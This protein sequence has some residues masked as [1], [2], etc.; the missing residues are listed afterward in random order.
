[1]VSIRHSTVACVLL[2][3]V[4]L[5]SCGSGRSGTPTATILR[6][7]ALGQDAPDALERELEVYN[8]DKSIN[9]AGFSLFVLDMWGEIAP[10]ERDYYDFSVR[11][12]MNGDTFVSVYA[13]NLT[14]SAASLFVLK[15]NPD[16]WKLREILPGKLYGGKDE[17]IFLAVDKYAGTLPFGLARVR[18]QDNGLTSGGGLV[19]EIAFTSGPATGS[20][21]VSVTA[22]ESALLLEDYI[23]ASFGDEAARLSWNDQ[24]RGDYDNNGSVGISDI[25]PIAMYFGGITGDSVG[26]DVAEGFIDRGGATDGSV[27]IA[28]I[29]PIAMYYGITIDGYNIYRSVDG[30]PEIEA[31]WLANLDSPSL[32]ISIER[33]IDEAFEPAEYFYQDDTMLDDMVGDSTTFVYRIV[34][35]GDTGESEY[36]LSDTLTIEQGEDTIPPHGPGAPT[37]PYLGITYM[38]AGD[39]RIKIVYRRNAVDNVTLPD[40]LRYFLYIGPPGGDAGIDLDNSIVIEVTDTDPPYIWDSLANGTTYAAYLAAEDEAGNRTSP[41]STA[42]KTCTPSAAARNDFEPPAWVDTIGIVTAEPGDHGFRV[43]FGSAVDAQSPPVRYRVYFAKSTQLRYDTAPFLEAD[44]SPFSLVGMEN[45]SGYTLAVRAIDSADRYD[46][47]ISPNEESN[48]VTLYATPS[49]TAGDVTPPTWDDTVGVVHIMPGEGSMRVEFGPADDE[50]SPPVSYTVYYQEGDVVDFSAATQ[51]LDADTHYPPTFVTGLTDAQPYA[52]VVRAKDAA[53]NEEKNIET[54]AATPDAGLDNTPPEWDTTVGVQ[55]T[56]PGNGYV[57][58]S[59]NSATDAQSPPVNYR[60]YWELGDQGISDYA[61]AIVDGRSAVISELYYHAEGLTNATVYSF[62]VHALDSWPEMQGGPNE[63][64]N[65]VYLTDTPKAGVTYDYDLVYNDPFLTVQY[66]S[67]DIASDGSF[68]VAYA[69]ANETAP[70]EFVYALRYATNETG[71]WVTEAVCGGIPAESRGKMASLQFD[72]SDVP[73]IVFIN[74][75]HEYDNEPLAPYATVEHVTR[76][77]PDTWTAPELVDDGGEEIVFINPS[78]AFDSSGTPSVAYISWDASVADNDNRLWY[79]WHDGVDW[80]SER[81]SGTEQIYA[82]GSPGQDG[83]N[84]SLAFGTWELNEVV[85]EYASVAYSDPT[86]GGQLFWAVRGGANEWLAI[87][88]DSSSWMTYIDLCLSEASWMP[89]ISYRN[90]TSSALYIIRTDDLSSWYV[91]Q[92]DWDSAPGVGFYSNIAVAF[93]TGFD[94][95]FAAS[96]NILQL[97]ARLCIENLSEPGEYFVYPIQPFLGMNSGTYLSM[98]LLRVGANDKA[99]F[100]MVV[101]GDLYVSVMK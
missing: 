80:Q 95:I 97:Q 24:L 85:D 51:S 2:L 77:A 64:Y 63:D 89:R 74:N 28:E 86:Q 101:A 7:G 84:C 83:S 94:V 11:T 27:G 34:P 75:S 5:F 59:W 40:Q 68:G 44:S 67:L 3:L 29:T 91:D 88:L 16:E 13:Q 49:S 57:D 33:A 96:Y 62:A 39:G 26:D 32:E 37:N 36:D 73:H 98:D 58:L 6:S 71:D 92:A 21:A 42:V 65:L 38:D 41:V 69:V 31:E 4:I 100:S 90:E 20:R 15:Y 61:Q 52:F 76:T 17:S 12:L 60:V 14:D 53:G 55:I 1:M 45:N 47:P 18:P 50:D 8:P 35:V 9:R 82:G 19:A 48:T 30:H 99:V 70:G 72:D 79:A 87:G 56:S 25:T 81:A 46:P 23:I 10:E 93:E 78:F 66:T 54:L 43:T 22:G